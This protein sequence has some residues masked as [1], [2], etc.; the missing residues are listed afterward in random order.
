MSADSPSRCDTRILPPR[1]APGQ[2]LK[3]F[4]LDSVLGEGGMGVV[5]R[6]YDN[7][8]CR[9]VA[10]KVLPHDLTAD[11]GRKQRFLQE[12]R[13]A[14]R[15]SHPAVAQIFYVDEQDSVTF[16]V[17][18]LVEGK[19]VR[20]LIQGNEQDLLGTIE[21]GIQVAEGLAKAHELGV[22]HR[23]IKPAN[24]MVTADGH[25]KILD[26][27]L[28]KLID[29]AP[30][31]PGN[32]AD[33]V[34]VP[35]VV[36]STLPGVVMGTA[37][38][39]SP[40][41]VRAATVDS[42]TDLF[43]L[44]V[45]LYEMATGQ[46]PF[47]RSSFVDSLHAVAYDDPPPMSSLRG[48]LPSEF[49]RIVSLCLKKQPEE[50][51]GDAK[52]LVRDLRR[53]RRDTESGLSARISWRAQVAEALEA[54][55]RLPRSQYIWLAAPW[56]VVAM[57]LVLMFSRIGPAGAISIAAII[58]YLFRLVRHR[59][60]RMQQLFVRKVARL[61]EVQL[62]SLQGRQFTV[63]VQRPVPQL[64]NRIN[65][66]LRACNQRLYFGEPMTV[67]VLHD[68]SPMRKEQLL[69]ATGVQFVREGFA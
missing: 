39:M 55:R 15:I 35:P 5:F 37:A 16:I 25:A 64:Y 36:L 7:Q 50:R 34:P 21:V 67:A 6:G 9:S 51:Y 41:Q 24:V 33:P 46:S 20:E 58:L 43:S 3:Q 13:A 28:A 61:P 23:D 66:Q 8:L 30:D 63:V 19:T 2:S 53:L 42:R 44:G 40:E 14:A 29:R 12:A 31:Q 69:A 49:Q 32:P 62:I 1:L 22:V 47:Q 48:N 27:G 18:E 17:M 10:I 11:A 38:Y 56:I 54:V 52:G 59:P 57:T 65:Q 26:F 68:V 45:L 60:Q 4:R